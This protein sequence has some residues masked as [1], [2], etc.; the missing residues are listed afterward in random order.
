MT[1]AIGTRRIGQRL[2]GLH[3]YH[4]CIRR[5]ELY[6]FAQRADVG[7][8]IHN[9]PVVAGND[10]VGANQARRPRGLADP[11]GVL[12]AHRHNRDLRSVHLADELH[13]AEQ[14]G[15]GGVVDG[16][17]VVVGNDKTVDRAVGVEE[18]ALRQLAA[19]DVRR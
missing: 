1:T 8:L 5:E 11:H 19:D 16:D 4:L 12:P 6:R 3:L 13:I 10:D 15:V 14:A 18:Q 7:R 9:R 2:P 17:A